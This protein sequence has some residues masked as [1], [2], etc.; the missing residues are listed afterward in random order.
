MDPAVEF[1]TI[2][3]FATAL[4]IGALIGIERE[5]RKAETGDGATG[6]LRTFIL[7]AQ[8][9]AS[10]GWISQAASMPWLLVRSLAAM[11]ALMLAGYIVGTRV[12][13][14]LSK[15]PGCVDGIR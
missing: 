1:S 9:G 2:T 11:P 15:R 8:V 7:I 3:D 5:K 6:G 14:L 4:L 13:V 12:S 10:A